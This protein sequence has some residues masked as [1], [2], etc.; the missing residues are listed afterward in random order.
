MV[1]INREMKILVNHDEVLKYLQSEKTY[2]ET[3]IQNF[4]KWTR[5]QSK[6]EVTTFTVSWNFHPDLPA[7]WKK[8]GALSSVKFMN[9]LGNIFEDRIAAI[10]HMIS[11]VY[12]PEDIFKLW[13]T[14]SEEGWVLETNLP[15]G[16][17]RKS[18]NSGDSFL[19]PMMKVF[20]SRTALAQHISKSSEFTPNEVA[21]VKIHLG[22]VH[23]CRSRSI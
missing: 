16:W 15:T 7:G 22:H 4:V 10:D 3:D 5:N 6:A 23:R 8:S 13:N 12:K 20:E 17:R 18:V 19:S 1:Q 9:P 14:L 11:E 21:R 2:S